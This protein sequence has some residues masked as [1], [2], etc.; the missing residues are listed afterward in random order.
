VSTPP[1][2]SV[3]DRLAR[4]SFALMGLFVLALFYTIHAG[5]IFF[6]PIALAILLDFLLGPAV[7]QMKQV[8]IPESVGAALILVALLLS[9][10]TS[11]YFLAEPAREWLATVPSSVRQVESKIRIFRQPVQQ[12]T[13]TAEQ[14]ER[15][16]T[17]APSSTT[18]EVKVRGPGLAERLFGTT[19]TIIAGAIEV[20]VLL[21]FLLASGERLL[22]KVARLLPH[23]RNREDAVSIAREAEASI[24]RYLVTQTAINLGEGAVVAAAMALLDVPNP[25]IWGACTVL[26]EYVPYVGATVLAGVLT[27]VAFTVFDSPGR[28]AL[29]PGVFLVI[30]GIVANFVTPHVLGRNLLLSPLAVFVGLVFW[31]WI[32]G[33][34]GTF[35]AVPLLA[36]FRIVCDRVDVLKPV[37]ALLRR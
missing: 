15:A 30:V 21:Y 3:P 24:S 13:R 14:V 36:T 33:V 17:V 22:Q 8:G 25:L 12:V 19:E 23:R 18:P 7:R 10:A 26:V 29:V 11:V 2:T 4:A 5:R 35:L 34:P 37:G 27:L 1:A 32:W 6:L 9:L 16:T 31:T 20:I 28:I